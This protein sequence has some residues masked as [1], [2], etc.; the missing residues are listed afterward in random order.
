M[1]Q[2]IK[3]AKDNKYLLVFTLSF[4]AIFFAYNV[5]TFLLCLVLAFLV[6][7]FVLQLDLLESIFYTFLLSLPFENSIREWVVF[8]APSYLKDG[9]NF[10]FGINPKLILCLLMILIVFVSPKKYFQTKIS[11]TKKNFLL[12]GFFI[13]TALTSLFFQDR[14][15]LVFLGFIRICLSLCFYFSAFAFFSQTSKQEVFKFYIVSLIIFSTSL[16]LLQLIRQQ[17]LGKYVELTPAFSQA[18][19]YT[20]DGDKQYRLSSFI[21]HPVYFGSFMSI[22]IPILIGFFWQNSLKYPQQKK[23]FYASISLIAISIIVMLGSLSRSTWI[24]LLLMFYLFFLYWKL[25]PF[26]I[27]KI[28]LPPII[29][30]VI[31]PLIILVILIPMTIMLATRVKSIGAKN[32]GIYYRYAFFIRDIKL[33]PDRPLTGIGLNNYSFEEQ[34]LEN[35]TQ[36]FPTPPHNTL[37]IFFIEL[38]VPTTLLFILFLFLSL[39]IKKPLQQKPLVFGVWIGLLTFLISSQFH[40]LFNQDPTFDL[41]MLTLGFFSTCQTA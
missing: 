32:G 29:K 5:K 36:R 37:L 40:P 22:L 2:L 30:K 33:I 12:I 24:N 25:H 35:N 16:G 39:N 10:V 7:F 19:F 13:L 15:T 8:S 6:F 23:L 1:S 18:G 9:Y 34:V 21:S 26:E 4:F 20:T 3:F 28:T 31:L 41:F 27:P 11:W 38:G 14:T 17:P